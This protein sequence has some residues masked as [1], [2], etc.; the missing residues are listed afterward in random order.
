MQFMK[1]TCERM[2]FAPKYSQLIDATAAGNY[3]SEITEYPCQQ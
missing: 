3:Q 1:K 2:V